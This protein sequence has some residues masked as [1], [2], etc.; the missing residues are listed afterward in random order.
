MHDELT[1]PVSDLLEE[2]GFD[3]AAKLCRSAAKAPRLWAIRSWDG[4]IPFRYI[5]YRRSAAIKR[6][7]D[8]TN[9]GDDDMTR[10][11]WR[12]YRAMGYKA[13]RIRLIE[14]PAKAKEPA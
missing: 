10:N 6:F 7:V 14:E 2:H 13:V 12:E 1:G 11:L 9:R 5:D 4:S 8:P 3:E